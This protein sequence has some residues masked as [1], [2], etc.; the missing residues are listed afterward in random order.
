MPKLNANLSMMFNEAEF[1]ERFA[2]AAKAGFK[3]VE[4]LFPYA[5]DKNQLADLA[6]RNRL[7]VVLFNAPPG[8]WNA[9][10]RGLACDPAR[11]GECEEGIGK[12]IDYALTLGCKQIHCL[13]GLKPRGV[14]EE[15]MRESYI[16]NLQFAG[17][18][19]AKH[20][21]KLLIEAI[22]TRDIPGFYLNT[23]RQAFDIMHY[24]QVANLS[25][26][27]DIY[28]MQI[29][30]GDLAPTI[31]KNLARIGHMQLAD[32]PGR[33]EPG[34]GEINYAFLFAHIDRIGYPG[35]IGCE[36]RPA[37]TTEAGLGWSKP[38]LK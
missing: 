11:V 15:R 22:N 8:D 2:L 7:E 13:A 32:T 25:F 9:G 3:G 1:T 18:E 12:A 33:H 19:L 5:Y 37:T 16:A 36:Y 4:F 31:E 34:T 6:R 35:W 10:D 28:H 26:Q 24:A 27:Y 14:N 30:E 17:K 20:G 29:M 23:S 38:Y 21:L